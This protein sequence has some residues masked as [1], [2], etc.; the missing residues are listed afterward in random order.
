[1]PSWGTKHRPQ[2][3]PLADTTAPAPPLRPVPF[4]HKSS[5][6]ANAECHVVLGMH[7]PSDGRY[8]SLSRATYVHGSPSPSPAVSASSMS[9]GAPGAAVVKAHDEI[10]REKVEREHHMHNKT[11]LLSEVEAMPHGIYPN[12]KTD[13]VTSSQLPGCTNNRQAQMLEVKG[14]CQTMNNT[15]LFVSEGDKEE[16]RRKTTSTNKG[17]FTSVALDNARASDKV[18]VHHHRLVRRQQGASNIPIIAAAGASKDWQSQS[19]SAYTDTPQL[20]SNSRAAAAERHRVSQSSQ[21][22]AVSIGALQPNRQDELRTLKQVDFVP[23]LF[24]HPGDGATK[25][26]EQPGPPQQ[27]G[28]VLGYASSNPKNGGRDG[29]LY[30]AS[31]TPTVFV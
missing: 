12:A 1:M 10:V 23:H 5:A 31:Y 13:K 19:Q 11:F 8:Q 18:D 21:H 20:Q 14:V 28:L 16:W 25:A 17:D 26:T 27:G 3:T 22:S 15:S 24:T 30:R 9:N 6:G 4:P 29:S 7:E 2:G